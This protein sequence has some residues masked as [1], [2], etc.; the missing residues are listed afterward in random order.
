V[1]HIST[2]LPGLNCT[3]PADEQG[4]DVYEKDVEDMD[5]Q[6]LIYE[7]DAELMNTKSDTETR[8]LA[9]TI[10]KGE[11]NSDAVHHIDIG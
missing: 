11:A 7:Q 6:V 4:E 9:G 2:I 3:P 1:T 10:Q 5:E 8:K